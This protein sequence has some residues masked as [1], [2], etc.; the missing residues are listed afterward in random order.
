MSFCGTIRDF[1][2]SLV[3]SWA[4]SL[5]SIFSHWWTLVTTSRLRCCG[6]GIGCLRNSIDLQCAKLLWRLTC[7]AMSMITLP[8]TWRTWCPPCRRACAQAGAVLPASRNS[9]RGQSSSSRNKCPALQKHLGFIKCCLFN[10]SFFELWAEFRWTLPCRV[11]CSFF[12]FSAPYDFSCCGFVPQP[13]SWTASQ[14]SHPVRRRRVLLPQD[15]ALHRTRVSP[16]PHPLVVLYVVSD[17]SMTQVFTMSPDQVW[18]A[19]GVLSPGLLP[20]GAPLCHPQHAAVEGGG[21]LLCSL[22]PGSVP[23]QVPSCT[24]E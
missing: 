3:S 9:S 4:S 5:W 13:S 2:G 6:S 15:P 1:P 18:R 23:A 7:L 21:A 22:P 16:P 10:K 12:P 24:D 20:R 11:D 14:G 8:K 17:I 19:A